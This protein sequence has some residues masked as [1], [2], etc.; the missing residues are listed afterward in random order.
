MHFGRLNDHLRLQ[1]GHLSCFLLFQPVNCFIMLYFYFGNG[2]TRCHPVRMTF[3]WPQKTTSCPVLIARDQV[4]YKDGHRQSWRHH[5][6]QTAANPWFLEVRFTICDTISLRI[7]CL[8]QNHWFE[9]PQHQRMV[10][11]DS[12]VSVLPSRCRTRWLA[13]F[14][15]GTALTR[16]FVADGE[17][18]I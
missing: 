9:I 1:I 2:N 10:R 14:L 13:S 5:C 18:K 16:C 17:D 8:H 11:V 15:S 12:L 6:F 7:P 4:T 3:L